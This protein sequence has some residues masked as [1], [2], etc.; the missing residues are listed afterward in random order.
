MDERHPEG[1]SRPVAPRGDGPPGTVADRLDG[2]RYGRYAMGVLAGFAVTLALWLGLVALQLGTP[3][4]SSRWTHE[5]IRQ[6]LAVAEELP[7]PRLLVVAG[8]SALFNIQAAFLEA[9]LGMPAVNLGAQQGLQLRYILDQARGVARPGDAVL[10]ALEYDLYLDDGTPRFVQLDYI[11]SR[12]PGYLRRTAPANAFRI[13]M[14]PDLVRLWTGIQARFREP[15]RVEGSYDSRTLNHRGDEM[16]NVQG[17]RSPADSARV[18][19]AD[20]LPL[21]RS[22]ESYAW[23]V[24]DDF[25]AWAEEAGVSVAVTWPATLYFPEYEQPE[26]V[27]AGEIQEFYR[28][29]GIP[30]VGSPEDF[31]YLSGDMYDTHYHLA[32]QAAREN[33]RRLAELLR[34]HPAFLSGL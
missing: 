5:V 14:S 32:S 22:G 2:G 26:A 16:N 10:L 19:N 13:A 27:L 29:R 12:D 3:T 21:Y 34:G 4:E 8:S 7:T 20:P 33:S 11:F 28:E 24:L 17:S 15:A 6:K 23:G 25:L 18:A 31:W 1:V 30:V 9:E